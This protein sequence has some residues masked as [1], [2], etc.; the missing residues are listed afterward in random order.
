MRSSNIHGRDPLPGMLYATEFGQDFDPKNDIFY[1]EE[2]IIEF[3]KDWNDRASKEIKDY[4]IT[5]ATQF[6]GFDYFAANPKQPLSSTKYLSAATTNGATNN[7]RITLLGGLDYVTIYN[8]APQLIT[9]DTNSTS[10]DIITKYMLGIQEL[11][12]KTRIT[13]DNLFYLEDNK[14]V[15]GKTD[16]LIRG[17]ETTAYINFIQSGILYQSFSGL[18]DTFQGKGEFTIFDFEKLK[19]NT[20]YP[21]LVQIP[22][23]ILIIFA[24][25]LSFVVANISTTNNYYALFKN[26]FYFIKGTNFYKYL[27]ALS[28][29][30]SKTDNAYGYQVINKIAGQYYISEIKNNDGTAINASNVDELKK[31][32]E[33]LFEPVYLSVNSREFSNGIETTITSDDKLYA[34]YLKQLLPKLAQLVKEDKKTLEDKLKS[35]K[36][37][38]QDNDVKLSMYKSFQVIYENYLYGSSR[39]EFEF[40]IK[41]NFKFVDRAYNDI[42]TIGVLDIKTLLSDSQ[43][44]NVSLLT[45]ISRLLSDNNYWFYPFQG[46]L[47]TSDNYNDLFKIDYEQ[48]IRTEPMFVAM[49]VGGLSSN[50]IAPADS[51]TL[52]NDGIVEGQALPLDF[53]KTTGG[54]NA[55][56][57][58]YTGTQNQMVFSDFQ[59]STE[60]LKNTDEGL[61]IQSEIIGNAS[62][63]FAIPKGQS[64]LT[65]YQKQSY[66]STVKIPFGNMGIQPTQYYYLEFIPIF[67]GLYII[68]SVSHNIN[69]DTQRLETTFKGYRVK[70][71]VNPII[72]SELVDFIRENFYTQTL[73]KIGFPSNKTNLTPQEIQTIEKNTPKTFGGWDITSS[74]LRNDNKTIHGAIDIGT[75]VGTDITFTY[76]DV[77]FVRTA[78]DKGGYGYYIIL[79]SKKDKVD[80]IFAHLQEFSAEL[81]K[82]KQ[83]DAVPI[84]MILGKTGQSGGPRTVQASYFGPHLHFEVREMPFETNKKVSYLPYYK[85]LILP[86]KP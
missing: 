49:Y 47:T 3:S 24:K 66:T 54:F 9:Q 81:K 34:Q 48:T 26:E 83:G 28:N 10:T 37:Q 35:Y 7:M 60:S 86:K 56:K 16:Y 82:L 43:D 22:K 53:G 55:F 21:I 36:N 14:T 27:I 64:L 12:E 71:D 80:F 76:P 13:K 73:D 2:K 69:S 79:R 31:L 50:P 38:M 74:F 8:D 25:R 17:T 18:G 70:K 78:E 57:V 52:A 45:A 59:H 20:D 29:E 77:T 51:T 58:K 40:D 67:E 15:D 62:N 1:N 68:Y 32:E 5:L 39:K 63:S 6:T 46:F 23:V 65:V 33:F 4:F 42:S 61:R 11:S 19:I 85:N 30:L 44:T 75:D 41:T 84:D 72:T